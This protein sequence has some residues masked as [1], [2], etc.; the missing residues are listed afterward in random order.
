LTD[1]QVS[2][3]LDGM[4][5]INIHTG[6]NPNGEIRGQV[7]CTV[8]E[9][10]SE[11]ATLEIGGQEYD[12]EYMMHGGTLDELTADPEGNTITAMI[13]ADDDGELTIMLPRE[14]VDSIE[15]GQDADYYVYVDDILEEADDDY[16]EDVR[17][18]T[19]QFEAGTEQID[20]IGTS[21][22]PEFGTVAAIVLAVAIVGIIVT[23]TRYGKFSFLS[24]I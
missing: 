11:T 12:I 8:E 9:E 15:N 17:T 19:I 20:I 14:I 22:V 16:G 3:L 4:M 21:V 13:T 1:D 5:Y 2:D 10:E 18:L 7:E 24:K 6:A 23:T